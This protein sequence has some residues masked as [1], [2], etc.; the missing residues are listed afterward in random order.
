MN[1]TASGR[2]RYGRLVHPPNAPSPTL[3]TLLPSVTLVSALQTWNAYWPM[4]LTL[5]PITTL[6]RLSHCENAWFP[7]LVTLSPIATAVSL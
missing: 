1:V 4:P 6:V 3:L 2:T 7:I 5:L